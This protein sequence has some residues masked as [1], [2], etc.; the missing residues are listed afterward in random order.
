MLIPLLILLLLAASAA[1]TVSHALK[2]IV[3]RAWMIALISAL[4]AWLG[5]FVL[6]LYLPTSFALPAWKPEALFIS[7][8]SLELNYQSWPYAASLVTLCTAVILTDS[9]R[10]FLPSS[11]NAWATSIAITAVNLIGILAGDPITL[12]FAWVVI[13][14]I[15]FIHLFQTRLDRSSD[16]GLAAF[17]SIR[18]LSVMALAAGTVTGWLSMPAFSMSQIPQ[19]AGIYFLLAAGLRLGVLP[20]NL[21]VQNSSEPKHGSALLTRLAPVA[22]SLALIAHLPTGFLAPESVLHSIF[23]VLTAAAAL[24]ASGMWLSRTNQHQALPYWIIALA[25]FAITCALNNRA[26]TS[27]T[28]GVALLLSGGA[29]FLFDPPIRRIRFLPLLGLIGLSALPYTLSAGGWDGLLTGGFTLSAVFMLLSH[30][31]LVLGFLRY[32]FEISGTVTG[33]EKHARITYPLG[34]ILI[35]QTIII[36]GL[37]G[38]PG[39]VTTGNWLASLISLALT[40]LA[41]GLYLKL[42]AKLPLAS[43]SANLPLSRFWT[44]LLKSIQQFLSLQWLY[45]SIAWLMDQFAALAGLFS[46]VLD[47]EGGILWSLVFLLV[48]IT[49]F[50]SGVN[51]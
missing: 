42:G 51:P 16:A 36:I 47:G 14:I 32:S 11:P 13:D 19:K 6:R 31:M 27:R 23:L 2:P 34:L 29:L 12:M 35:V 22:S 44:F 39:V 38:W 1:I 3:S 45:Q 17:M 49:L 7:A 8:P 43:L 21:P 9:T 5:F 30:V 24:Y 50:L 4:A 33:L 46:Q 41:A 40:G 25:S 20:L 18:V 26:E 10:S 48:L 28:W 15:E 37:A